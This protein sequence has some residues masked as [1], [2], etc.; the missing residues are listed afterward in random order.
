[1]GRIRQTI[2]E[3]ESALIALKQ[4]QRVEDFLWF[5]LAL[6]KISLM[7]QNLWMP[8]WQ[9]LR[10]RI[11]VKEFTGGSNPSFRIGGEANKGDI[12]SRSFGLPEMPGVHQ[13]HQI[14]RIWGGDQGYPWPDGSLTRQI[15]PADTS[16]PWIAPDFDTTYC[17]VA[18]LKNVTEGGEIL[19]NVAS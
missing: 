4:N 17:P 9:S 11:S 2:W 15:K 8:I 18:S 7:I 6:S 12:W 16:P 19:G 13:D 1:M 14:Y 5:V 3:P 10:R